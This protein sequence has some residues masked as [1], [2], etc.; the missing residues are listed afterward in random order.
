[1]AQAVVNAEVARRRRRAPAEQDHRRVRPER[2]PGQH[3]PVDEGEVRRDLGGGHVPSVAAARRRG[4]RGHLG[5]RSTIALEVS[6]DDIRPRHDITW[7]GHACV[8]VRTP[9]GKVVLIDPWFGNPHSPKTADSVEQCDVMLVT[10]GHGDHLG[11]SVALASRLQPGLAVHPR[12]EPVA[13]P[14]SRRAAP[15][16]TLGFNK[17]GTVEVAGIKVTMVG[18]DHSSGD[19]N[20]GGETTLYLGEPAGF[21]V[22]LENGFTFYHAGDTNVFTDMA[23]IGEL[24][25]PDVAFLP[26][27][28]HFTMGPREAALA[29]QLLGV[30]HVDPDPLRA[31]SRSSPGRRTSCARP[32]RRATSARSRCTSSS[33][34]C[35]ST[36]RSRTERGRR[37]R[38][39]R[40]RSGAT[41]RAGARPSRPAR[42]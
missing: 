14:P 34:A 26:I 17:G 10:H 15:M 25:K 38:R 2:E 6:L 40:T 1:M 37:L 9:G 32:S 12:D 19:W 7:Y 35:R 20:A 41:A 27:G 42:S 28:G 16:P 4:A 39:R 36:D 33:R 23:L 8:E 13:R 29:V 24:Y 5:G 30:Q 11:E 31:P 21:V 18:A 3:G 22:R